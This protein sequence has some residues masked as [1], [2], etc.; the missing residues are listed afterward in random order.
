MLELRPGCELC[1]RDLPPESTDAMI[2]TFECT[3]C[4]RCVHERLF[5][6]CPNCGG[7]FVPR[8]IRPREPLSRYPPSAKRVVKPLD[9]A[10][11]EGFLARYRDM[12]PERR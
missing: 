7:G 4:A 9:S 2:C 11:H 1:D 8:P 5:N 3:F 6:V 10:K 12:P